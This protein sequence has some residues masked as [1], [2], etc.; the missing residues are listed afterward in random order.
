MLNSYVYTAEFHWLFLTGNLKSANIS[1]LSEYFKALGPL[2]CLPNLLLS[3]V[4]STFINPFS[5]PVLAFSIVNAFG[6]GTAILL[7]LISASSIGLC[8]YGLGLFFSGDI[9]ALTCKKYISPPRWMM[10]ALFILF[11]IPYI[12]ILL[13]AILAAF[14]Q[15]KLKYFFML[16]ITG[17]LIRIAFGF[18]H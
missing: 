14:F 17:L 16:M 2:D 18:I 11:C 12:T 15:V 6:P 9:L 13:P 1:L 4:I 10:P 8:T 3:Q 7:N 5:W